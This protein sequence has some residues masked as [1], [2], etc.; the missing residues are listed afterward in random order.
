MDRVLYIVSATHELNTYI[1][2]HQH[3]CYEL[4]YYLQ[5]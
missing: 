4:V 2:P 1:P 3:E 5:G